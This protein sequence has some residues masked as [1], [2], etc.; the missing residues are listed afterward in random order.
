[1]YLAVRAQGHI[2]YLV[3]SGVGA[4]ESSIL[5]SY[6]LVF[7]EGFIPYVESKGDS[8]KLG[9]DNLA[10]LW[11]TSG[12]LLVNDTL[13]GLLFFSARAASCISP[14]LLYTSPSPRDRQKSRMP[15]SA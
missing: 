5:D 12:S 6:L 14:C 15:S 1:M 4:L 3:S 11:G 2:G 9:S 10:F 13:L 8:T 7:V